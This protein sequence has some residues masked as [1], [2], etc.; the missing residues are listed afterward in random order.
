MSNSNKKHWLLLVSIALTALLFALCFVACGKEERKRLATPQN[1]RVVDEVLVWDEVAGAEGYDVE[2]NGKKYESETNSLDIFLLTVAPKNYSMRVMAYGDLAIQDDSG[3]SDLLDY[4]IVGEDVLRF[5]SI[6][7]DTE[8]EVFSADKDTTI[9]K[10]AIPSEVN[11]KPVTAIRATAFA[12][13]TQLV[14][15]YIPDSV[16]VLGTNAFSK[17]ENLKRVR[18]S[19]S[20][21]T[22][23][24]MTFYRCSSLTEVEIPRSVKEISNSVF[25]YCTSLESVYIPDLVANI[26]ISLFSGCDNLRTVTV[27]ERNEVYKSDGNCIIKRDT[28]ELIVGCN[29]GVIPDYV[30]SIEE[31]AFTECDFTEITI[32]DGVT[33]IGYGAFSRCKYLTEIT[34]PGSV[35]T[36]Y[37][38]AFAGCKALKSVTLEEGIKVLHGGYSGT[39]GSCINLTNIHIP[40]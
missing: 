3:W 19:E 26:G 17:C 5:R 18:L 13:C 39:F 14:G 20:L 9:G 29:A 12:E 10:I 27:D 38:D 36:I 24:I 28:D 40:A 11:G 33:F 25:A 22:L 31:Y 7:N 35:E 4:T 21:E 32:P 37:Y 8:Y 16:T 6:N 1:L 2:I 30:K 34:I 15:V 23:D